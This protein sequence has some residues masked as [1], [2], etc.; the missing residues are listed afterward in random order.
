MYICIYIERE[1]ERKFEKIPFFLI[2][3]F[4]LFFLSF[5]FLFSIHNFS[6][7]FCLFYIIVLNSHMTYFEIRTLIY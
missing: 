4:F 5:F 6:W 1:G 7:W 3:P 2:L